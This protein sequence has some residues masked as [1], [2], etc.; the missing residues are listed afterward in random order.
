MVLAAISGNCSVTDLPLASPISFR[1]GSVI[2][3]HSPFVAPH[4]RACSVCK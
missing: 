4:H 1:R 3:G 2:T